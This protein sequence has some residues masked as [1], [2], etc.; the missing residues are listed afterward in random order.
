MSAW[1]AYL[2]AGVVAA[3]GVG[4]VI[5][6]A[7]VVA[8]YADTSRDN[9]LV[10]AKDWVAEALTIW[11]VSA[12]VAG[13]TGTGSPGR[14]ADLVYRL[15]ATMLLALAVLTAGTGARTSVVFFKVCP[16]VMAVGAGLLLA[17][18]LT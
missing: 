9:R 17:A 16:V 3:W 8:G 5:P 7:R 15:S 18:S 4:H 13:V 12:L 6:T 14:T 11:F 10:V 1:F 2:G